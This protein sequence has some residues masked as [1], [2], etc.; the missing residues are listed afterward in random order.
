MSRRSKRKASSPTLEVENKKTKREAFAIR[1]LVEDE[2]NK[3]D[4]FKVIPTMVIA[5]IFCEYLSLKDKINW[6]ENKILVEIFAS[7]HSKKMIA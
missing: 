3:K 6:C 2:V 7:N 1:V 5:H 4:I